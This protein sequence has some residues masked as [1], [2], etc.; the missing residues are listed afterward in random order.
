MFDDENKYKYL[1][2][3][4]IIY[5]N[6]YEDL[7]LPKENVIK[8]MEKA[9]DY[10]KIVNLLF[11]LGKD[12]AQFL[13]VI[14][15]KHELISKC[16]NDNKDNDSNNIHCLINIEK[17]VEP[18]REDDIISILKCLKKI[19]ENN[20]KFIKFSSS[21]FEKYIE[22]YEEINPINLIILKQIISIIKEID[23][24]FEFK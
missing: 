21:M 19:K 9:N 7:L 20:I 1:V 5:R 12:C 11:Y 15:E 16:F 24:K 17:Y 23:K 2:D 4:L 13:Q 8:L 18:K 3:N 10:N 14:T 22:F 6:F